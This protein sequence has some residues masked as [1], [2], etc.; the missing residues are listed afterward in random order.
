MHIFNNKTIHMTICALID[1]IQFKDYSTVRNA[2]ATWAWSFP[3]GTPSTSNLENPVVSYAGAPKGSTWGSSIDDADIVTNNSGTGTVEFTTGLNLTSFSQFSMAASSPPLPVNL[4]SFTAQKIDNQKALLNWKVAQ[5]INLSGYKVDRSAD[6]TN[7]SSIGFVPAT[8]QSMYSFTDVTPKYGKNFYRLQM[9]DID[10]RF[11]YSDIKILD[12]KSGVSL[13]ISPNPSSNGVISLSFTGLQNNETASL[14]ITNSS[15]QLIKTVYLNNISNT[16]GVTTHL[17]SSAA[18][19]YY[20]RVTLNSGQ[21][22]TEK[23]LLKNQ[24]CS[25]KYFL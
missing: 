19:V 16:N 1:T 23:L 8:G 6:G 20:I 11:K 5:E 9:L 14:E 18:G 22:F 10:G 7:Y 12:F 2:S 4:L 15:G 25:I 13:T 21:V 17:G 3:G 24:K